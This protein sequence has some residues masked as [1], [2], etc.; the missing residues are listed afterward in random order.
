M[1]ALSVR[2]T[3]L[4]FPNLSFLS[5]KELFVLTASQGNSECLFRIS[6][7]MGLLVGFVDFLQDLC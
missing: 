2:C 5:L 3:G 4:F 7:G 1:V 6:I